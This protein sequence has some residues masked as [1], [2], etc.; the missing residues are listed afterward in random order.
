VN[1]VSDVQQRFMAAYLDP[2]M[3]AKE[4]ADALAA[5]ADR[6]FRE[7]QAQADEMFE[8]DDMAAQ[9]QGVKPQT[10]LTTA[11]PSSA[12]KITLS[13]AEI[14]AENPEA[15]GAWLRRKHDALENFVEARLRNAAGLVERFGG[16]RPA[17]R[18]SGEQG[19]E[20]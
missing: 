16:E 11:K 5:I 13:L 12:G 17:V 6:Q 15:A 4:A 1:Q 20:E 18:R 3:S 10:L 14:I 19:T 8:P 9:H 2:K 7:R